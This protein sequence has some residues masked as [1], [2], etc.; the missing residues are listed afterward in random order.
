[1]TAAVIV[2]GGRGT[3]MGGVDKRQIVVEGA[4]IFERQVSVLAPR[5]SEILVSARAEV[6]GFR[7]VY[8]DEA[9][10]GPLAGVWAALA[11]TTDDW[12]LVVAGD[13]PYL[14]AA[15]IDAMLAARARDAVGIRI[16]GRIE[17]LLCVL[18]VAA[19]RPV[20]SAMRAVDERRAGALLERL[21]T[22]WLDD[23]ADRS[24]H[25]INAPEDLVPSPGRIR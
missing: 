20:L 8:D 10:A 14:D 13:M 24:L 9:D 25:S 4:T 3:R 6:A 2:A 11:A 7:T 18:R 23:V 19:A 21:D 16:D 1:M 17:P 22:V 15:L 12:L 5:T